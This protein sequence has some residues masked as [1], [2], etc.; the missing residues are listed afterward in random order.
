MA[1]QGLFRVFGVHNP[2][3]APLYLNAVQ[4]CPLIYTQNNVSMSHF[5]VSSLGM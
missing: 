2:Y 4:L 5:S 1:R 3:S